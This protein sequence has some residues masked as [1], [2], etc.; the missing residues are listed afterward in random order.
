MS[1]WFKLNNNFGRNPKVAR[2]SDK[3]FRVYVLGLGYCSDLQT[4]GI[5]GRHAFGEVGATGKAHGE[6]VSAGL[7]EDQS[8]GSVIVHDYLKH[9][10]SR[11]QI[12]ASREA[13][14]NRV[15]RHRCNAS[16]TPLQ[17]SDNAIC[18][19]VTDHVT[20]ADCT[21]NVTLL[22]EKR[23]E[24][25]ITEDH[26]SGGTR[27]RATPAKRRWRKVPGDWEPNADHERIAREA[28]VSLADQ[29][30]RFRDHE[31]KDP[32]SD[33]D[34]AF[35]N[36]LRG[37]TRYIRAAGKPAPKQPN[38]GAWRAPIERPDDEQEPLLAGGKRP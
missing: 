9:Q 34:A 23:R 18:N 31:F 28:G 7:W 16:V 8:D 2:L 6:L 30:A 38:G 17:E 12:E 20:N 13:T 36:W 10:S 24:D 5:I 26:P 25:K 29:L 1:H 22:E 15:N 32:K 33:A 11:A 14:R 35:R 27:V 21:S 19:A 3:A 37:S 4:D